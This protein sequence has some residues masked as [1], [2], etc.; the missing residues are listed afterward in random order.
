M[1]EFT[2]IIKNLYLKQLISKEKVDELFKNKKLTE[3]EYL[4]ILGKE[5]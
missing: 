5:E 3:K 2:E 1:I 4:Y